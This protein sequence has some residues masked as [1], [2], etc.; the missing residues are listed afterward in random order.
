M[1][2]GDVAQRSGVSAKTIRYYE[3]VGLIRPAARGEN[4][5][6]NYSNR[7]VEILRF[8]HRA[9][10]LGFSVQDVSNLLSLWLDRKRASADVKSVARKHL[11]DVE[12]RIRQLESIRATLVHLM[13][14]CHGDRRPDCPILEEL[15]D[16]AQC[17]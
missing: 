17:H 8:I 12:L 14:R 1:K 4:G 7:D 16:E 5:Y 13:Q 6:R 15:A 10:S 11:E 3:D 2:I 9:R